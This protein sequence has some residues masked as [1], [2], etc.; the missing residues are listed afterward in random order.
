MQ[1]IHVEVTKKLVQINTIKIQP[2]NPFTWASGWKAPIYCDNRKILSYP[3]ARTFIRDQFVKLIREQ[4]PNA[5]VIAGVAT[6]A[7]AHGML[8]AQELGLPFIY[9]R[10][11]PKDHGLENLIE[12][13]L[14]AGQKVVI[15]ED[16]V[17]T[18]VSSLKAA[19]AISNFGGDVLGMMAIFT[20]N[21]PV[22]K[23]NFEKA[24]IELTTL[25]R[26]KTLIEV[27]LES[28]EIKESQVESLNQWR[29]DPAN[30]GR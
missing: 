28:G 3:E 21:F 25:S 29:Q 10:S 4:Y 13:D 14:K 1:E 2:S 7:I 11:K 22:A 9:V 23:E 18:G 17:S 16:L 30:W 6:G 24:G 12:G 27:A 5:E 20:Y 19:E 26:Y 8:V 15:I